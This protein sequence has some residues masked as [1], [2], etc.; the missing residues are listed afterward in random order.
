M[1]DAVDPY[2]VHMDEGPAGEP[3]RCGRLAEV[4][5]E[6][7]SSGGRY[8]KGRFKRLLSL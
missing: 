6:G 8:L 2:I 5:E 4:V 7:S 3:E 1:F